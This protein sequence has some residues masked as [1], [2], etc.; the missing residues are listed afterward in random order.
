MASRL[1][2]ETPT[3]PRPPPHHRHP[4]H[5]PPPPGPTTP[6]HNHNHHHNT[7]PHANPNHSQNNETNEGLLVDARG[8][9]ARLVRLYSNGCTSHDLNRYVEVEV[10]ALPV[11]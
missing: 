3:P 6:H 11:R 7:P 4:P 2:T 10:F 9:R 1:A 5:S 8:A